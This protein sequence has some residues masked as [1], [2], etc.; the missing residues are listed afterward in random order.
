[1][2][3]EA[4][5][6]H[7]KVRGS[8][9]RSNRV[10][11]SRNKLET[12]PNLLLWVSRH[13]TDLLEGARDLL[14]SAGYVETSSSHCVV[15]PALEMFLIVDLLE[16]SIAT[17]LNRG[18]WGG[19]RE[20]RERGWGGREGGEGGGRG[21]REGGRWRWWGGE[22]GEGE[23]V[24]MGRGWG[25]RGWGGERVGRE[26]GWGGERVGRERWWG[27]ESGWGGERVGRGDGREGRGWGGQRVGRERG[28]GGERVGG[29]DGGEGRGEWVGRGE[30]GE[31]RW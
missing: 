8:D 30:G 17:I 23:R 19:E 7:H 5:C 18:R 24:G 22:G 9:I 6:T 3:I 14:L 29:G 31:G 20:G 27:G 2:H 1:M 10:C 16:E 15:G 13:S 12:L 4:I 28:W 26:R 21:G 11:L 25:G